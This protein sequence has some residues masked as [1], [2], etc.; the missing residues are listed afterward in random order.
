MLIAAKI[1]LGPVLLAQGKR[2]RKI[3]L[4]LPEAAPDYPGLCARLES[5]VSLREAAATLRQP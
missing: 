5:A 3:A 2:L 1:L 4:R